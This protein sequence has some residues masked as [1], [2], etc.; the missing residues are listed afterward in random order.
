MKR[1]LI[2]IFSLIYLASL[3]SFSF[4]Q[5]PEKTIK[6]SWAIDSTASEQ[7]TL[8]RP[9]SIRALSANTYFVN[10][11]PLKDSTE[12]I[13]AGAALDLKYFTG[14]PYKYTQESLPGATIAVTV[15]VPESAISKLKTIPNKFQFSVKSKT[16]GNWVQ[17]TG[18]KKWETITKPGIYTFSLSLPKE[19]IKT[20]SGKMFRPENTALIAIDYYFLQGTKDNNFINFEFSDFTISTLPLD[21]TKTKW[22]LTK[23]GYTLPSTNI[24]SFEQGS[25]A[26]SSFS[27]KLILEYSFPSALS[28]SDNQG[29]KAFLLNVF[30][31]KELRDKS[32]TISLSLGSDKKTTRPI[33]TADS[34]GI[35]SMIFPLAPGFSSVLSKEKLSLDLDIS[36][37][38]SK[39]SLPILISPLEMK[40]SEF[41]I[42]EGK[43]IDPRKDAPS[44]LQISSPD[45]YTLDL[46]VPLK[47]GI[48][49]LN[50]LYKKELVFPLDASPVD[51]ENNRIEIKIIP[52]T[53]TLDRWQKPYRARVGLID[54]N[55]KKLFGPNVSLSEGLPTFAYLD[56]TTKV[57]QPKGLAFP[58]FDT[59]KVSS[60]IINFEASP[61]STKVKDLAISITNLSISP[62][63]FSPI[64]N[65]EQI[66]YSGFKRT[67]DKWLITKIINSSGGYNL[68]INYPSPVLDVPADILKVPQIYPCVG[69]KPSDNDNFG[70]SGSLT[71]KT[72]IKDFSIFANNDIDLVR[73][74]TFGHLEGVFTWDR[75]GKAIAG[76]TEKQ[77]ALFKQALSFN[78]EDFISFVKKN[79]SELFTV[80]PQD[81]I[82]GFEK[83]VLPDFIALFD[84]LDTVE[85]ETGRPVFLIVSLY[86]FLLGDG[87]TAEGPLKEF[88]AGEHPEVVLNKET[89]YKTH[90][91]LWKLMKTLA[92]DPRFY[93][94]IACV[95]I[96]NEP[97]NATAL[98]TV[99]NFNSFVNFVGEGLYLLKD[100][101][102][103]DMPVSVG[104]RSWPEDLPFWR[105]IAGG[106]DILM[107]HYWESLESYNID[108]PEMWPIDM[109]ADKLWQ[110]LGQPSNGR[111]TGM[112]EISPGGSFAENLYRV[113]TAGYD[114]SLVWS[115]SGHDSFNAKPEMLTIRDFQK[116]NYISEQLT[117]SE[118]ASRNK[119]FAFLSSITSS[120]E[121]ETSPIKL[122]K[123][124]IAKISVLKDKQIR[125]DIYGILKIFV[126]KKLPFSAT[127]L[128]FLKGQVTR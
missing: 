119:A 97:A 123:Y 34:E 120:Y 108:I 18:D 38:L 55:G 126:L 84:I 7:N 85:K 115:Y 31:P 54:I 101:L 96:M 80:D 57:P 26:I 28:L 59:K 117:Q 88:P 12:M 45:P 91:L 125:Q 9:L 50:S 42:L 82:S 46:T 43:T 30:L 116:A 47:G 37:Q 81:N 124:L 35:V 10:S 44:P 17:Y 24:R 15:Y 40:S 49:K 128:A 36:G 71:K 77:N 52:R 48:D 73:I 66:N 112:G 51:L 29:N 107:I 74:F 89:K 64:E 67:P 103:P 14:I 65:L 127:N 11:G 4:A 20:P 53:D 69:R 22:L 79:E 39:A 62:V 111:L 87:T 110:A 92:E 1:S 114:F 100:V 58:G 5:S 121:K 19:A 70:F 21:Q 90:A 3:C 98:S 2:G 122:G 41:F 104:F 76:F 33:R 99:N 83:Q 63:S 95:E 27:K 25:S 109:P 68:G 102:G 61:E 113:E 94:Y 23:N 6:G 93:K 72:T 13:S 8:S 60:I 105:S 75:D 106:I 56:V 16:N 78:I 86:D 32:G 118:P